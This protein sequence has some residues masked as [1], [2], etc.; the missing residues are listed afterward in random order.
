MAACEAKTS[1]LNYFYYASDGWDEAGQMTC[2]R[3][4]R[5]TS[6]GI[7]MQRG[8]GGGRKEPCGFIGAHK[9]AAGRG[10]GQHIS[11]P[12]SFFKHK[13]WSRVSAHGSGRKTIYRRSRRRWR[14]QVHHLTLSVWFYIH[15]DVMISE[16]RKHFEGF[17]AQIFQQR[18]KSKHLQPC[19][20][21]SNT[22]TNL[23][24]KSF[25]HKSKNSHWENSG[26]MELWDE[27]LHRNSRK[28]PTDFQS[29]SLPSL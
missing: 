5:E 16:I 14:P 19:A 17:K 28:T 1:G 20:F 25:F 6:E 24:W 26:E 8:G 9:Q 2:T 21:S 3:V 15:S 27:D 13:T 12:H 29:I 18:V 23:S 4:Y 7:K 11:D 22:F 10:G